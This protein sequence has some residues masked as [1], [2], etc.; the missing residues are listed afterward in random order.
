MKLM[1]WRLIRIC[2]RRENEDVKVENKKYKWRMWCLV[3][4]LL[5]NYITIM[6]IIVVVLNGAN[7]S[8]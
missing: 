4:I 6:G 7:S 2:L 8:I 5:I 1:Q 3:V